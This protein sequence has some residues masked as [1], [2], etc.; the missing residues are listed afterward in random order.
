MDVSPLVGIIICL[1]SATILLNEFLYSLDLGV[2]P[3]CCPQKESQ[4]CVE[5]VLQKRL[6]KQGSGTVKAEGNEEPSIEAL[7]KRLK[8][9]TRLK[10]GWGRGRRPTLTHMQWLKG[11]REGK[12][13]GPTMS[14]M[15]AEVVTSGGPEADASP[16]G[17]PPSS[18]AAGV[19]EEVEERVGVGPSQAP[20]LCG[21]EVVSETELQDLVAALPEEPIEPVPAK[22][23]PK[24]HVPLQKTQKKSYLPP[25]PAP[26]RRP[27]EG[28]E[29][30]LRAKM[31]CKFWAFGNCKNGQ[32]CRFWHEDGAEGKNSAEACHITPCKYFFGKSGERGCEK[33]T[34]IPIV[35]GNTRATE[36]K[37]NHVWFSPTRTQNKDLCVHLSLFI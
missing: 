15:T 21:T 26:P 13:R 37:S 36:S 17:S 33:G 12:E 25:P 16:V 11:I 2:S 30:N 34:C 35:L 9:L 23:M 18:E 22:A 20:Y 28:A 3:C 29:T 10:E 14:D 4:K 6:Q 24:T 1:E 19:E 5:K 27:A 32:N 8:Y 31:S 7:Q